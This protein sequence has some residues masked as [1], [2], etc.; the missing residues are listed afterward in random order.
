MLSLSDLSLARPLLRDRCSRP[1]QH[2]TMRASPRLPR[3][4]PRSSF[5][6]GYV[7]S[8]SVLPH[9]DHE[10]RSDR[11]P[12]RSALRGPLSWAI[13]ALVAIAGAFGFAMIAG[14]RGEG[15]QVNAVWMI[16]AGVAT[17]AIAY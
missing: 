7:M 12:N 16:V 9:P 15:S 2:A 10:Y 1:I 11:A 4:H 5:A 14:L 17:Y 6:Q 8:Q 13:W 3:I